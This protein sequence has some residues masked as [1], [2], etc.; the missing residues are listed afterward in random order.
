M[1]RSTCP[2]HKSILERCITWLLKDKFKSPVLLLKTDKFW[3]DQ[4]H[5]SKLSTN[6]N[7]LFIREFRS[8]ICAHESL[9]R[10]SSSVLV[11]I[12]IFLIPSF[13]M[14]VNSFMIFVLLLTHTFFSL[15]IFVIFK[16]TVISYIIFR[17]FLLA[18]DNYV[19]YGCM[20]FKSKP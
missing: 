11:F 16:W 14:H 8:E 15:M 4:K 9:Q 13:R 17:L 20:K 12:Y 10:F 2:R 18:L 3:S 6:M 1:W 5:P 7:K 19:N